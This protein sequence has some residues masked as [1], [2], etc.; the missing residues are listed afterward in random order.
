ML[1]RL[2]RGLCLGKTDDRDFRI[3]GDDAGEWHG[4]RPPV[5][6]KQFG[7]PFAVP[8][9]RFY[10]LEAFDV[11]ADRI[12]LPIAAAL[13]GIEFDAVLVISNTR[14]LEAQAFD[15]RHA[16]RRIDEMRSLDAGAVGKE[17]L[18][19]GPVRSRNRRARG[20]G[21]RHPR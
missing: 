18:K 19:A 3:G 12:N 20:C 21:Y 5:A 16:L 17:K 7:H 2:A 6:E 4:R 11:V 13:V 15:K 9:R 10:A 8:A 14:R 1:R